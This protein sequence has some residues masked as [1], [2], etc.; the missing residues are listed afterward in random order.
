MSRQ[1]E[2]WRRDRCLVIVCL[3]LSLL[4]F[5]RFCLCYS[6]SYCLGRLERSRSGKSRYPRAYDPIKA[7]AFVQADHRFEQSDTVAFI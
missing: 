2:C 5:A 6:P 3:Y 7:L 4:T 1:T